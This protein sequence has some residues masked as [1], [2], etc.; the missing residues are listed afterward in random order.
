M[1]SARARALAPVVKCVSVP[2]RYTKTFDQRYPPKFVQNYE[3]G[4]TYDRG[5]CWPNVWT[6]LCSRSNN[7]NE[8]RGLVLISKVHSLKWKEWRALREELVLLLLTCKRIWLVGIKPL[9]TT[10]KQRNNKCLISIP[11]RVRVSQ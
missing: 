5:D 3:R 6:F 11:A 1:D 9:K 2:L 10:D 8:V 7:G 4:G